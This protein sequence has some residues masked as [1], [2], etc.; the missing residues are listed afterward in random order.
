LIT[1]STPLIAVVSPPFWHADPCFHSGTHSGTHSRTHSGTHFG[2]HSGTH[3]GTHSG[4]HSGTHRHA[5]A[6]TG[7]C[8]TH[9][10][11]HSGTHRHARRVARPLLHVTSQQKASVDD[12]TK[13]CDTIGGGGS[14]LQTRCWLKTPS[15]FTTAVVSCFLQLGCNVN[16][17]RLRYPSSSQP[18]WRSSLATPLPAEHALGSSTLHT[19]NNDNEQTLHVHPTE[20]ASASRQRPGSCPVQLRRR[21][22]P[23]SSQ[24]WGCARA[25]LPCRL[26]SPPP[27]CRAGASLALYCQAGHRGLAWPPAGTK[28]C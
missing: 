18:W 11:A 9:S 15:N 17:P 2:K 20:R 12:P 28:T 27:S 8:G 25:S 3:S 22:L 1:V 21:L 4:A 16:V 23:G 13:K 19:Y 5:L 6:R 24:G 14:R 7:T 10:G 26:P